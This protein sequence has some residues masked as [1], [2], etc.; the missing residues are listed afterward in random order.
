MERD[1]F[2]EQFYSILMKKMKNHPLKHE[3][4]DILYLY[5]FIR[6]KS[7]DF[8]INKFKELITASKSEIE[9][10]KQKE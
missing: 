6:E 4:I 2:P 10:H 1:E 5:L 9:Q 3:L 7:E 8:F